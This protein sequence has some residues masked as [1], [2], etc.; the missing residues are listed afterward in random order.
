MSASPMP[1]ARRKALSGRR[2]DERLRPVPCQICGTAT[3]PGLD[4]GPQPVGDL[5]LSRAQLNRPEVMYPMQ[6]HH[7]GNCGLTQLGYI[8]NPRVV[9]KN[10]PFVSGT[11]RTATQH[12]QSLPPRLVEMM[13]LTSRSLAVDIGSNDGTLL[14]AFR[15]SGVR[16]LGVDPSGDPVRIALEHGIP[17]MHAFFDDETVTTILEEHGH[18]DAITACGVFGHIADLAGLMRAVTR[19]L[20]PHG[21]FA[22]DSQYWLDTLLRRHYDNMF[23]QHLRYYSMK[24]LMHLFAQYGLE[25]FDVERSEVY[26]GSIRVFAAR[27]GV[28]SVSPRVREL[29]EL[30]NTERLCEPETNERF[31]ADIADRRRILFDRAHA[32]VRGGR[33]VIGIGAPAKAATVCNYCRLGPEMISYITEVNPL[34]IG[35][36]LPGVRIPIIDEERMF[37]DPSPADAAVLF[38]WNYKDEIVPRLRARGFGGEIILP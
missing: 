33:K 11:T 25:A 23:H 9:Y 24:P 2:R 27:R 1:G 15:P 35:K 31:A 8:V 20:A 36:Y 22:T 14:Q 38:A 19:L 21:V 6:L 16:I 17:T 7:C 26:G 18:A 34:R 37:D 29:L 10:F 32:L 3:V 12:L 4:I 28:R 13:G 5:V 30:E